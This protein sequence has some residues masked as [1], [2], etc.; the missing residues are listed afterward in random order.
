M[1]LAVAFFAI[2]FGLFLVAMW[3]KRQAKVLAPESNDATQTMPSVAER[4]RPRVLEF[5]VRGDE[6]HVSF[7]VPLAADGAGSVLS[8][9]LVA[10]AVEV[11]REKQSSLPISE[12]QHVVAFAGRGGDPQEVGRVTLPE[13]GALPEPQEIMPSAHIGHLGFDPI[14]KQFE[15]GREMSAPEIVSRPES[16]DLGPLSAELRLPKALD[17]GLR[18]QGVD[19]ETMSAGELVRGLLVSFGYSVR[20]EA[21]GSYLASK[22]GSDT[23]IAEI[24]HEPG[25]HPELDESVAKTFLFEFLNSKTDRG[26]LVS[27]KFCPFAVYE[28]ERKE[29]RVQFVTRERLQSFVDAA[30]LS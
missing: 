18:A 21:D 4:T 12:V 2:A 9:L 1:E 28:M 7:D 13:R 5:H 15:Q 3:Q 22:A 25:T 14:E 29:P 17:F 24:P 30:S 8:E 11:V 27:D 20:S 19:P 16:D 23:Y 10:E 26:M 6:A